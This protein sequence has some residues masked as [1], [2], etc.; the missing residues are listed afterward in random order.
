[1]FFA[2][3]GQCSTRPLICK[4]N[5]RGFLISQFYPTRVIYRNLV[6]V[7]MTWKWYSST[8]YEPALAWST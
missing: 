2:F 7:K 8:V 5:F 4:L 1:M 3:F 6:H